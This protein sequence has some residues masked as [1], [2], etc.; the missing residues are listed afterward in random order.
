M[1]NKPSIICV[2]FDGT[3]V[4][5]GRPR[6]R[7]MG[8]HATVYEDKKSKDAKERIIQKL[9]SVAH[10][11]KREEP[12]FKKGVPLQV[13]I[14]FFFEIPKSRA[15][16]TVAGDSHIIKPDV[17]NLAKLVLDAV[18]KAGVVWHDD[19][20]VSYLNVSKSYGVSAITRLYV[21]ETI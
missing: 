10:L 3:P 8:K 5:Q 16:T 4:P 19:S 17:D 11:N 12:F 13:A 9:H 18:T 21:E 7:A 14:E 6:A 15:K 1:T 2:S 20:Q